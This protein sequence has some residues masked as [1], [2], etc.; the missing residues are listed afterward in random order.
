MGQGTSGSGTSNSGTADP[1]PGRR[2]SR[3]RSCL[4][5]SNALRSAPK[6]LAEEEVGAVAAEEEEEAE[7]S[8]QRD[9]RPPRWRGV[10]GS[11][12]GS[13]TRPRGWGARRG[14]A[15]RE[16]LEDFREHSHL[17]HGHERH[18]RH[19][20]STCSTAGGGAFRSS[21]SA[22][23]RREHLEVDPRLQ[24]GG[25]LRDDVKQGGRAVRLHKVP[26]A[27][28]AAPH[29][30]T[31]L[32]QPLWVGS[33]QDPPARPPLRRR[34]T[35]RRRRRR[36][37]PLRLGAPPPW[38]PSLAAASLAAASSAAASSAASSAAALAAACSAAA[39]L[40]PPLRRR[41]RLP[42]LEMG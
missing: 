13:R 27:H 25:N 26:D 2:R 5:R 6:V 7:G 23:A 41:I 24:L 10:R 22:P 17:S 8:R 3:S 31:Q 39:L 21:L 14:R 1:V 40:P 19:E 30:P 20:A 11:P 33:R 16:L 32:A 35:T 28:L 36:P 38:P 42:P 12:C 18:E 15:E 37:R 29:R 4:S 34:A 9:R